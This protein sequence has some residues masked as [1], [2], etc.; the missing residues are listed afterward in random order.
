MTRAAHAGRIALLVGLWFVVVALGSGL[1]WAVISATGDELASTGDAVPR[2][3][4]GTVTTAPPE[5]T[6]SSNPSPSAEVTDSAPP[7]AA[8][9]ASPSASSASSGL[10]DSNS[11]PRPSR[12]A[13]RT[14]DPAPAAR[15]ATWS[16]P[17][18]VVT[19]RC[20]GDRINLVRAVPSADGYVVEVKDQGP[21]EV[22][23]EFEGRGED[24]QPE[25]RVEATCVGGSPRY[26]VRRES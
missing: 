22:E 5:A 12:T 24:T 3:P 26:S 25:T 18:G 9:S 4:D 16:G 8:S 19:T 1:V 15:S 10:P 14:R 6:R 11:G 7:P 17:A 2:P 20:V 13:D 21:E 23:V